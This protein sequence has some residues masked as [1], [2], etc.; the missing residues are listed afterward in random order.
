[1]RRL[2]ALVKPANI[3]MSA[4]DAGEMRI[5]LPAI[6]WHLIRHAGVLRWSPMKVLF[7]S[8]NNE[9]DPYPVAPIGAAYVAK[10]LR[11][12][13]HDV[14]VLDLCFVKDDYS[15]I[16]A[17]LKDF[18]P[19]FIGV[20]IR[21]ID[22]LTNKKSMFYMP[23]IR[24]ITDFIKSETSAPIVVGGSGFSIFPEEVL[25]YL[26]VEVGI[27]GEGETAFTQFVDA[28]NN[29]TPLHT[30]QNLCYIRDGKFNANNMVFTQIHDYPER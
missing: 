26:E 3:I 25:K 16:A 8:V 21:N 22:N 7:I 28:I 11:S 6:I 24:R 19:D 4:M 9:K 29:D 12:N 13:H 20:S 15:V 10:A 23:R 27:I 30:I 14:R 17:S 5:R 18:A 1:M 2:K